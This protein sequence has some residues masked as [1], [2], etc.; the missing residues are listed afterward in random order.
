MKIHPVG[1]ELFHADGPTDLTKMII[2]FRNF[3]NAPNN[4][5][6]P[7]RMS[8]F[9]ASQLAMRANGSFAQKCNVNGI[10]H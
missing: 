9:R 3:A 10:S 8:S 1:T 7:K 4:C 5:V 6:F 2:A